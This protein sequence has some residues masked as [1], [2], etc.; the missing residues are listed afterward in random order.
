MAIARLSNESQRSRPRRG[1]SDDHCGRGG[2]CQPRQRFGSQLISNEVVAD[3]TKASYRRWRRWQPRRRHARPIH[4]P[5]KLGGGIVVPPPP[6]IY[7]ASDGSPVSVQLG[8]DGQIVSA[9]ATGRDGYLRRLSLVVPA[10][11]RP[12]RQRLKRGK[13]ARNAEQDRSEYE[14][15]RGADGRLRQYRVRGKIRDPRTGLTRRWTSEWRRPA[16]KEAAA[17]RAT[18]IS[19]RRSG[20]RRPA[21]VTVADFAKSWI[22][23]KA[24]VVSGFTLEGYTYALDLHVCRSWAG[25]TTTPSA[26]SKCRG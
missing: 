23:S 19:A 8:A 12:M 11:C 21:R 6:P 26:I 16:C 7:R 17:I 1:N 20:Q 9:E 3:E 14:V 4:P 22:E 18:A 24:A 5:P 13:A 25:S 10:W 2:A 15:S